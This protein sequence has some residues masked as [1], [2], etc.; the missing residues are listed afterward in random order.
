MTV[1]V[2]KANATQRP[3]S[4]PEPRTVADLVSDP[5]NRRK[6]TPR[7]LAMI[8]DSLRDVGA[9]RSIVI[10]EDNVV[11]AGNGVMEGA[12]AAGITKLHVV[13]VDGDTLVAVRR[14]G[15]TDTQ[16]RNL[17][18]YDNRTAE[19]AEW[20]V[21]QLQADHDAGLDLRPFWTPEEEAALASAA[22]AASVTGMAGEPAAAADVTEPAAAEHQ[23]F[24][25]P[26]TVTQERTVRAALRLARVVFEVTTTGDALTAALAAWTESQ[27]KPT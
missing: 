21:A 14:R 4:L 5:Q 1:A 2:R 26:L 27:G 16:K 19:L 25:C 8:V 10:D 3:A 9:A 6:R 23:S 18:I 12:A 20:D 7:N 11:R 22:A 13:D 24:S 15:L 17:A